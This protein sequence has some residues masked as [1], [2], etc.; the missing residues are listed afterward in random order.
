MSSDIDEIFQYTG[1]ETVPKDVTIVHFH[2]SVVGVEARTFREC[3]KLKE[4]VLNS[5]LQTIGQGAFLGC[6]QLKEVELNNGLRTIGPAAFAYC[7]SLERITIPSSVIDIGWEAFNSCSN[8]KEVVLNEGLQKIGNISFPLCRSLESI[9]IPSTVT[10]ISEDSFWGCNRLKEVILNDGLEKIERQ[11]FS[12][13]KSLESITL[14]SS[15]VEIGKEAFINCIR[16]RELVCSGGFPKIESSAFSGCSALYRITF[17]NLSSRLDNIIRAGQVDA[18]NMIQFYMNRGIIEW[19]RGGTIYIPME[20]T[21][22]RDGLG[23][24]QQHVRHIV[25]RIKYYEMKEATTLFG[26][27]LW[28]AKIDQ[29]ED[30]TD[31]HDRDACRIEVPGPVKDTILQYLDL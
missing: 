11:A 30:S 26:L 23:I 7:H 22:S 4:V 12:K 20:V 9:A 16:L 17:P 24:V 13:C 19:E 29:V 18:Q 14:P 6:S 21:R 1:R 3:T 31:S 15:L 8:L 5:G 10:S 2:C 28:K 27:A 25:N